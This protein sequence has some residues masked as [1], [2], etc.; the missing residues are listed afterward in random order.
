MSPATGTEI[1]GGLSV[2]YRDKLFLCL[3][4]HPLQNRDVRVC[5]NTSYLDLYQPAN[6]RQSVK[7]W[8]RVSIRVLRLGCPTSLLSQDV[9]LSNISDSI[10]LSH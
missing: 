4:H 6:L 5:L 3:H 9:P 8:C 10:A 1:T 7:E 2:H